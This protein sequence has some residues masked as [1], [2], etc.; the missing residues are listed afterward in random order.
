MDNFM[1]KL[2][3]LGAQLNPLAKNIE[4]SF[5]QVKRYAEEKL[6]TAE[7]ITELPRPFLDMELKVN[8]LRDFLVTMVK[9][10]VQHST[11]T[12]TNLQEITR[13]L[14]GVTGSTLISPSLQEKETELTILGKAA[15][16]TSKGFQE[17]PFG[18]LLDKFGQ[19]YE[20]LGD[21]KLILVRALFYPSIS[22]KDLSF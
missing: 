14:Q 4:R 17:E 6:G 12:P 8:Q 5:G 20:Q 19:A 16:S 21:G 15:L 7:D 1:L 9:V 2:N 18:A 11:T 22:T 3:G 13:T 10:I